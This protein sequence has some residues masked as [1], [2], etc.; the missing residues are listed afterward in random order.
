MLDD[1]RDGET[2]PNDTRRW[3]RAIILLS[4]PIKWTTPT[5]KPN[6]DYGLWAI[7]MCQRT[8]L[9]RVVENGEAEHM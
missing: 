7:M 2:I 6:T 5:M 3:V 4:K 9:V 8:A 1:V